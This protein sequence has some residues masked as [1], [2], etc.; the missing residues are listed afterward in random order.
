MCPLSPR[1][2]ARWQPARSPAGCRPQKRTLVHRDLKPANI[3]LVADGIAEGCEARPRGGVGEA[4]VK[5]IDF[6][7]A[8]VATDPTGDRGSDPALQGPESHGDFFGTPQFASPEQ[9]RSAGVDLRS[10]IFS[11]GVTLWYLLTGELPFPG[12]SLAEISDWQ[13]YRPL[14]ES[15]LDDAGVPAPVAALLKSMLAGDPSL[16]PATAAAA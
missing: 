3:M 2:G 9:Y 13:T 4:W 11:L 15:Q 14:P 1:I 7:L 10:D 6:G 5:V 16:R 8:K 12:R